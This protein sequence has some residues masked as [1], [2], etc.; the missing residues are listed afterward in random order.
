MAWTWQ[1]ADI[2]A[3][4]GFDG[5]FDRSLGTIR[6]RALVMPCAIDLYFPPADSAAEVAAMPQAELRPID[7][8]WGHAAGGGGAPQDAAFIDANLKKWLAR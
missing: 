8:V 5:D 4:P 7:A 6:S 1:H 3:T 2:A